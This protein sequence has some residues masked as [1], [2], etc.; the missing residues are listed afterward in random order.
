MNQ[1]ASDSV[2]E[3]ATVRRSGLVKAL[4]L[5]AVL[6]LV[7]FHLVN[8]WIFVS[9]QVTILGWDRP[10]HLIRTLIYNDMLQEINL[11]SLFEV[12]TWSWNR[13]PLSHLIAVPFYRVFGVSTDVALM[14]NGLYVAVLLLSVY[15]IGRKMYNA[16]IGLL[17]A[18]MVSTYPILFSISG[19]Q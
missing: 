12:V 14:R 13:P 7:A 9:T 18:F 5:G 11:R 10:A 3:A 2:A 15:G 1:R 4:C 16:Q 8:N 6:G 19:Y 17:A